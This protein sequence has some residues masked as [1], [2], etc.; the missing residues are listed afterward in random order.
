[1]DRKGN[2]LARVGT[3]SYGD[4]PGRFYSPHGIA[5]DSKEISTLRRCRGVDYGSRMD[6]PR[7]LRSMQK[8]IRKR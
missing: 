5:V 1:M 4:E 7:E 3:N 6:P 2:V 8:L